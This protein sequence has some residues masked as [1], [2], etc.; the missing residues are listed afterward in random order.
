MTKIFRNLAL[1][2][3]VGLFTMCNNT[4]P[5]DLILSVS[6][7]AETIGSL[8]SGE[9]S[10]Y[11][12]QIR[13]TH[14][15]CTLKITSF[16]QQN[17][18]QVQ[19]DTAFNTA[20][21]KY[22]YVFTATEL[23]REKSEV[24]L[25]F[26]ATDSQGNEVTETRRINVHNRAVSLNEQT[27]IVLYAPE[28]GRPDALMLSDVSRPFILAESPRSD[29]IDIYI[30]ADADFENITM[31]SSTETKFIRMNTFIYSSATAAAIVSAY[32]N[33]VHADQINDINVNDIIIVGQGDSAIGAFFVTN[34]LRGQWPADC[35]QMNYKGVVTTN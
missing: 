1:L 31:K 22:D 2:V 6:P 27:G 30:E 4:E 13:T 34:I 7:G 5:D 26:I 8:Y 11:E 25:T 3:I 17:G 15:K 19:V 33:S 23:S 14:S 16:E 12:I 10:L 32:Q 24:K 9:K 18:L 28:S 21:A 29:S 35:M 20:E